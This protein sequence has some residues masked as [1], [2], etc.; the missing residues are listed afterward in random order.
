MNN[1][2]KEIKGFDDPDIEI[3]KEIVGFTDDDDEMEEE[4]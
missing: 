3:N 4:K 2:K 1:K